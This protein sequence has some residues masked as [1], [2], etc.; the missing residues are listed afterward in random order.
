MKIWKMGIGKWRQDNG[1]WKIVIGK[2][3]FEN[4]KAVLSLITRQ[5]SLIP[6]PSPL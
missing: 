3:K 2:S 4:G 1:N 5:T 6:V